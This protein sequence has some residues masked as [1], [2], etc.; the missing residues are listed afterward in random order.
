MYGAYTEKSK[1]YQEV[2]DRLRRKWE[3]AKEY[4]PGPV[5]DYTEKYR[6]GI[7]S[8]GSCDSAV[9][10]A[11]DRLL[12][13]G[14]GTNYL[15]V[16]AFPFNGDVQKFLDAHDRIYVV[17]QNRDAQLRSLLMLET[18]VDADKLVP[19]LFYDGLPIEAKGIIATIN[20]DMA[21]GKAA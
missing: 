6:V 1:E 3:T 10:E 19:A 18:D 5:V 16:K 4:V 17:E 2:V 15:R 8:I 9:R 7:I 12:E 20:E 14:I 13:S 21:K 11:R